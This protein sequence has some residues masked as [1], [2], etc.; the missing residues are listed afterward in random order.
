MRVHFSVSSTEPMKATN[1]TFSSPCVRISRSSCSIVYSANSELSSKTSLLGSSA[2]IWRHSSEPMEPP[3]P[4]TIT[5][6]P[7]MQIESNSAFGATTSLLSRSSISIWRT[8]STRAFPLTSVLIGG[9]TLIRSVKRARRSRIARCSLRLNCGIA[10]KTVV[11][12]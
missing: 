3:A 12:L 7:V 10:S 8:S 11:I 6:L 9:V 2:M 1:S 4:L 5:D